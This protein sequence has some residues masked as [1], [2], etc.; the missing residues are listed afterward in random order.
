DAP[1]AHRALPDHEAQPQV[2]ERQRLEVAPELGARAQTP[3]EP[4]DDLGPDPVVAD[5]GDVSAALAPRRRLA[6]VVDEG[7]EAKRLAPRHLVGQGLGQ[8]RGQLGGAL[9]R[10]ALELALHAQEL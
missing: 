1:A 6:Q 3:A 8:E 7:A 10:V 2:M 5:E 9:A 4:P